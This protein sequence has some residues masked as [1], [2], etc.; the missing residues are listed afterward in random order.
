M[1]DEYKQE[2]AKILKFLEK[3]RYKK[4]ILAEKVEMSL[5]EDLKYDRKVCLNCRSICN[6]AF[7]SCP[8]CGHILFKDIGG[9]PKR[10]MIK[11]ANEHQDMRWQTT[12]R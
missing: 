7:K 12:R 3:E 1:N 11:T 5:V 4:M 2:R 6:K 9:K 10:E 8:D